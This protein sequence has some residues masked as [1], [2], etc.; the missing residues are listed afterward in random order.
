NQTLYNSSSDSININS[1]A[2]FTVLTRNNSFTTKAKLVAGSSDLFYLKGNGNLYAW[3]SDDYGQEG[4][5]TGNGLLKVS[6][7]MSGVKLVSTSQGGSVGNSPHTLVL[8]GDNRLFSAGNNNNGQLGRTGLTSVFLPVVS[9]P[10][11]T[12]VDISAGYDHSLILM[13]NGDLYGLGNN[14]YGQLGNTNLGGQVNSFI[15]LATNVKAMAAGR[16]HTLYITNDG[17]LYG[18]GDNRWSKMVVGDQMYTIPVLITSNAKAVFAGEHSSFVIDNNNDLYYFGWRSAVTLNSEEG[19]GRLHKLLGNVE[20][21]SM[22]DEHAMILTLDG[23]A[24]GWGVNT[25]SQVTSGT[26]TQST[27]VLISQS[28]VGTAAGTGFSAILN[29]DGSITVWGK[30]TAGIA[31]NGSS[32]ISIPKTTISASKFNW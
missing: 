10:S 9:V 6:L 1:K 2:N 22:Q 14:T 26:V 17:A 12:I 27:P 29:S 21:V 30:N 13:S 31:G 4:V 20:S 23:K 24:Y 7:V 8:T 11:G 18:L 16:R 32:S 28:A 15:K 3:G 25:Y 5:Y 19:D